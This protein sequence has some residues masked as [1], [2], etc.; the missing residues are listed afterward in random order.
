MSSFAQI[1]PICQSA[2]R[3]CVTK[4]A[5]PAVALATLAIV[6]GAPIQ[7]LFLEDGDVSGLWNDMVVNAAEFVDHPITRIIFG[8]LA[9][10]LIGV[11]GKSV[12][13]ADRKLQNEKLS[14]QKEI[15]RIPM[16]VA[17]HTEK[18]RELEVLRLRIARARSEANTEIHAAQNYW[19]Q[20]QH[21][22][23]GGHRMPII[24]ELSARDLV[25]LD[26][27][28]PSL[29][30]QQLHPNAPLADTAVR[31]PAQSDPEDNAPLLKV[32]AHNADTIRR[33]IADVD[34][35]Y[36]LLE[37]DVIESERKMKEVLRQ[38]GF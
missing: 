17:V 27:N 14:E 16:M 3:V 18:A 33:W 32:A 26:F 9:L 30:L 7:A 8:L 29:D 38:H 28:A 11:A 34:D 23:A 6:G 1:V 15:L 37:R 13:D 12:T 25:L 35:A 10:W 19:S 5:V 24:P 31:P 2:L 36:G 21:W 4:L 22:Q 20:K